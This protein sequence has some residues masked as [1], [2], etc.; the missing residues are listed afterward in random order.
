LKTD[1][2]VAKGAE[3]SP[4]SALFEYIS[5]HFYRPDVQA[6][7]IALGAMMSHILK[8]GDPTWLFIVAPPACGKT[9]IS[10][11]GAAHLK[12]VHVLGDVTESTFLSGFYGHSQPGLLEKLGPV[13]QSG[14]TY[15]TEGDGL[16]LIKDF[17]TVLGMRRD[18]RGAV[19]SQLREIYDGMYR[20]DFGTGV[21]KIWKGRIG[22]IAA[23]TPALDRHYGVFSTLGERFLQVRIHRPDSEEAGEWAIKQQG[24]EATIQKELSKRADEVFKSAFKTPALLSNEM[25]KRIA[26]LAEIVAIGR[27]HIARSAFGNREIEYVPEPEANTRISKSL[28]SLAKGIAALQRHAQVTEDEFQDVVRVAL[29]SI[30]QNRSK[31]IR[32]IVEGKDLTTLRL[33]GTVLTRE[34]EELVALNLIEQRDDDTSVFSPRMEALL[35]RCGICPA[36]SSRKESLYAD[37]VVAVESNSR[38]ETA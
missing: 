23:V 7:R 24:Q 26:A 14:N 1:A 8:V 38:R 17:T 33:P 28:A 37:N 13:K 4:L 2:S 31:V 9:S 34:I 22:I 29:D 35:E 32:A 3:S 27:T 10:I 19:L 15:T 16:F 6:L 21:T 11:M 25:R 20:R 12:D 36:I 18:K 30:P 5:R